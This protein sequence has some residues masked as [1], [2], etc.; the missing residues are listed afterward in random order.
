[1]ILDAKK[2][3]YKSVDVAASED[4]KKKM[5]AIAGDPKA[6]PPQIAN[7]DAYCGV[8]DTSGAQMCSSTV[9]PL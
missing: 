7:G 5:R 1:M 9:E 8:S 6:L 4:A 2:I 3:E